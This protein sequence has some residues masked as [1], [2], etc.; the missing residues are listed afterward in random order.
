MVTGEEYY[1]RKLY[2]RGSSLEGLKK[3][4]NTPVNTSRLTSNRA[5]LWDEFIAIPLCQP[6]PWFIRF[7]THCSGFP[8]LPCVGTYF[9][10]I[11]WGGGWEW[12]HLVRQPLIGLLYQP[13]MAYE[14][15]AVGGM[16]IGRGNRST[17]RKP[18]SMTLCLLQITHDLTGARTPAS[19]VRNLLLNSSAT[20]RS[21][22]CHVR[23]NCE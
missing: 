7:T 6:A 12:V 20:V 19:A 23:C 14:C 4:R 18:A 2:Y 21:T 16:R 15:G 5:H 9:F 13:R 11:S 17:G 3:S 10:L 1:F 22:C 8:P